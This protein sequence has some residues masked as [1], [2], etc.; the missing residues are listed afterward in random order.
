MKVM[1]LKDWDNSVKE[2]LILLCLFSDFL[3]ICFLFILWICIVL[4]K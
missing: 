3:K 4:V 1:A 2:E